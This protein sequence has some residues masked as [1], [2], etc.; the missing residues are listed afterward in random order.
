MVIIQLL[1]GDKE[2][3]FVFSSR[4]ERPVWRWRLGFKVKVLRSFMSVIVLTKIELRSSVCFSSLKIS[5][6]K[7]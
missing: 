7:C 5:P 1:K 3:T 4:L 2:Q 6:L